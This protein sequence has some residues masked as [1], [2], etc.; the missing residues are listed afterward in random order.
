MFE[1][2]SPFLAAIFI[3]LFAQISIELPLNETTIPITGQTFAVLL[4][5][6]ILGRNKGSLAILIYLIMGAFGLPVFAEAASGYSTFFK[7]SGGYLYGFLIATFIVGWLSDNG[8]GKSFFN[9]LLL[10]L[11][12]TII[13]VFF[14]LLQL[15]FL[16]GFEKALEYGLYPFIRGAVI[17]IV[18]GAMALQAYH[19]FLSTRR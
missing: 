14:G 3:A 7:G 15:T 19:S 10:M 6:S 16:Y 8:W 12:G 13:I 4:V 1:K 5:A 17:K 2:A 18:L 9:A 11:I